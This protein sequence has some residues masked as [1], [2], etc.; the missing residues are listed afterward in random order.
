MLNFD[1]GFVKS[2]ITTN[3]VFQLLQDWGAEPQYT[4]FGILSQT[5]CHHHPREEKKYKLYYYESNQLFYCYSNCGSFDIFELAIKVAKYQSNKEIDLNDAVR[6]LA[7]RFGIIGYIKE[8]TKRLPDWDILNRDFSHLT[9]KNNRIQLKEYDSTILD[10]LSY[11]IAITP[12]LQ[13]GISQEVLDRNRIGFFPGGDQITIPHYDESGRFIG[14]RGRVMCE[15]DAKRF[16]KYRPLLINQQMY[17]HPLGLNLY[18]LNNS[19]ENI[20]ASRSAIVFESEKATMLYQTYFPDNDISVACCGSSLTAYQIQLLLDLG[21]NE[22]VVAFDRQFKEIGDKEFRRL[23]DNLKK[24]HQKYKNYTRI[25][26]IFDRKKI[27]E[28]KA[29]PVDE[30]KEKFLKLLK[31]KVVL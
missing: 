25:S 22:I 8:D 6:S 21:V 31:E 11:N 18:N 9:I 5:I 28:Y 30:S 10:R 15:F 20:K 24:I 1:K 3:D 26:F 17:N 12:W 13:E 7:Y 23:T 27:T 4:S 14:L 29:S 19:K 2:Q 16:G